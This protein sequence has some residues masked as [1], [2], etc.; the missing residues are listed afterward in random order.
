MLDALDRNSGA[1]GSRPSSQL[2][3][4]PVQ[5]WIQADSEPSFPWK[6]ELSVE[7]VSAPVMGGR[8]LTM[9]PPGTNRQYRRVN[10]YHCGDIRTN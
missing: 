5:A 2:T 7:N 9:I 4:R 6:R 8:D 10:P 1:L 3:A